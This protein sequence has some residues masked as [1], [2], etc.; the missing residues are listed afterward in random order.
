MGIRK[1]FPVNH[2]PKLGS[3]LHLP[4]PC[5]IVTLLMD[6]PECSGHNVGI[7]VVVVTVVYLSNGLAYCYRKQIYT[8]IEYV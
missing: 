7:T 6:T 4:L 2:I 1:K 8:R 3:H 5:S